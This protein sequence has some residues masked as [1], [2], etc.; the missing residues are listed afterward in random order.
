MSTLDAAERK[1][2]I[3]G[4]NI[5]LKEYYVEPAAAATDGRCAE[6]ARDQ[7]RL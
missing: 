4:V 1:K 6:K 7:R 2:V 3:D 5:D